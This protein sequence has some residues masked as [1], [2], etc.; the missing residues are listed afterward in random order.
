VVAA[1]TTPATMT[2]STMIWS[3]RRLAD[4]GKIFDMSQSFYGWAAVQFSQR[5]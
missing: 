3:G 5:H 2:S 1:V 4:F